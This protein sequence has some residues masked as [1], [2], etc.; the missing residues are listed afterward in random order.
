LANSSSENQTA[1]SSDG[2]VL[3]KIEP[4]TKIKH[5]VL[6]EYIK[7]WVETL[8]GHG[9]YGVSRFTIVDAYSGG[10]LYRD[11]KKLWEG[12]PLRIIRK[13]E[14]GLSNVLLRKPY[15]NPDFE[16][17]FIDSNQEHIDCLVLQLYEAGFGRYIDAKK[18]IIKCIKFENDLD[19]IIKTVASRK[20]HSFFFLD[21]FNLDV[22]PLMTKKIFALPK[23][24]VLL[25]HM[26]SGLYRILGH[27]GN[28][29]TKFFKNFG[30]PDEFRDEAVNQENIAK[31]SYLRNEGIR[32]S[33]RKSV[34]KSARDSTPPSVHQA[35][36]QDSLPPSSSSA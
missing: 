24:E 10:G 28:K 6:E 22:T 12:S 1:W 34:P 31:Y 3:P 5:K 25:N 4:H 20:G 32:V 30:Y 35:C 2:K 19:L 9:K 7:N 33:A 11:G 23:T 27:E 17:I 26:V 8:A 16:F 21:P 36:N 15:I 29:Y 14:E 18:C 13:F